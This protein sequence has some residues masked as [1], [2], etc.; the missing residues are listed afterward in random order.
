MP[1][2]SRT[3]KRPVHPWPGTLP[4]PDD[5]RIVVGI[6]TAGGTN[7]EL[8]RKQTRLAV[9]QLLGELLDLPPDDIELKSAAGQAPHI[10]LTTNGAT[11]NVGLSIS[12]EAGLSLA[13]INLHGK[14][15]VDLMQV[16]EVPDWEMVAR[17]YL[18]AAIADELARVS[19]ERRAKVF[20]KAWTA[21]E[22]SLKCQGLQLTEWMP[23]PPFQVLPCRS[24]ELALPEGVVGTLVIPA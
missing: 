17:D 23:S 22:A 2:S 10:V 3:E 4:V 19:P 1:V 15:G 20:A 7:R 12:H 14:V 8:A 21:R 18:G 24:F 16:Q 6:T 11:R 9:R 5:G 13:A